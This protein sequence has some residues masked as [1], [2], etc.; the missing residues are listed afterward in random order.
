MQFFLVIILLTSF[1]CAFESQLDV[2]STKLYNDY[3]EYVVEKEKLNSMFIKGIT[4]EVVDDQ[5]FKVY[6]LGRLV[7]QDVKEISVFVPSGENGVTGHAS[8][9]PLTDVVVGT[10]KKEE[11]GKVSYKPGWFQ[12][13]I[14]WKTPLGIGSWFEEGYKMTQLKRVLVYNGLKTAM[15]QDEARRVLEEASQGKAKSYEDIFDQSKFDIVAVDYVVREARSDGNINSIVEEERAV[16]GSVKI[17]GKRAIDDYV[18]GILSTTGADDYVSDD[19]KDYFENSLGYEA[20]EVTDG[21]AQ[22]KDGEVTIDTGRGATGE[23][24]DSGKEEVKVETGDGYVKVEVPKP[25][26]G[27][28]AGQV[29]SST[30]YSS[31]TFKAKEKKKEKKKKVKEKVVD[32]PT[33]VIVV[34]P[35]VQVIVEDVKIED[36]EVKDG[37]LNIEELNVEEL[38]EDWLCTPWDPVCNGQI[39]RSSIADL[40]AKYGDKVQGISSNIMRVCTNKVTNEDQVQKLHCVNLMEVDEEEEEEFVEEP[41]CKE[42]C[43]NEFGDIKG[44]CADARSKSSFYKPCIDC[45]NFRDGIPIPE[46]SAVKPASCADGTF[47]RGE[48]YPDHAA[49]DFWLGVVACERGTE[50]QLDYCLRHCE[51]KH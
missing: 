4:G 35:E 18:S 20:P 36:V 7:V 14:L 26:T 10:T 42:G 37:E 34:T 16:K 15:D 5:K 51:G 19:M 45:V 46:Y 22:Y 24:G 40:S 38:S 1:V 50:Q 8:R 43:Q 30:G 49:C 29:K 32:V 44:I 27:S 9:T 33:D 3:S 23:W 21:D 28:I 47:L 2:E 39:S 41:G 13:N 48:R 11:D 17:V 12:E 6:G 31:D 25:S